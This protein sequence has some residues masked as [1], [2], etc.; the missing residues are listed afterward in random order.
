MQWRH[1]LYRLIGK[2]VMSPPVNNG[3]KFAPA[4]FPRA[5]SIIQGRA[6]GLAHYLVGGI[7][8]TWAFFMARALAILNPIKPHGFKNIRF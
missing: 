1:Q 4:I 3:R 2:V 5:L 6:V 7:I 8:T